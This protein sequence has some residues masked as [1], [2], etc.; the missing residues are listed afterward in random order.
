MTKKWRVVRDR[1]LGYQVDVK[2]WWW[3]F[4]VQKGWSNT[5]RTKEIA[6]LYAR[7]DKVISEGEYND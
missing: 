4:W 1:F 2:V 7:E 5:H 6:E 3:P